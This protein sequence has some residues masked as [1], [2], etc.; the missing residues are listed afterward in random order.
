MGLA[1]LLGPYDPH[2]YARSALGDDGFDA[3]FARGRQ[4]T[5][6]QAVALSVRIQDEAW[7]AGQ[8]APDRT[9]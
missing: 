1:Q 8:A 9:A 2:A 7:G 5:L 4:M 6:D 3:A